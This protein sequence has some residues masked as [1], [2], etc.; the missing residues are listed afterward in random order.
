MRFLLPAGLVALAV[1]PG[2]LPAQEA[3]LAQIYSDGVHAFFRC[4][5]N[6]SKQF[7]DNAI[8][9][10][11]RD[12]RVYY[13]RALAQHELGDS[14]AFEEDVRMAATLEIQGSGTYDIGR[15]LER[16]QG[17]RR[18]ELERLRRETHLNLAKQRPTR[19][20]GRSP[21]DPFTNPNPVPDFGRQLPPD[22]TDPFKDDAEEPKMEEAPDEEPKA[23]ETP[24]A[25]EDQ[26]FGE[27]PAADEPAAD[28]PAADDA[29]MDEPAAED[30][31]GV[32]EAETQPEAV[33][34]TEEGDNPFGDEADTGTDAAPAD[35]AP[36]A[37]E[38]AAAEPAAGDAAPPAAGDVFGE[39]DPFSGN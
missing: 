30:A 2:Q 16:I 39:E 31:G 32:G 11:S 36:D 26:P 15:A 28:E 13:F 37:A 14:I 29:G 22:E 4:D 8:T 35:A 38:P 1:V 7:L 19:D 34:E 3:E 27:E 33:P 17:A 9:H 6:Q 23:E 12:P 24:P 20:P 25:A 18:L 5:P 10:G 21:A